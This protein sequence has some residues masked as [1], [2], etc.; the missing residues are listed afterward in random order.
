MLAAA[1]TLLLP[2][3]CARDIFGELRR[4]CR[5][6]RRLRQGSACDVP[7]LHDDKLGPSRACLAATPLRCSS[8]S[9]PI[10]DCVAA[11]GQCCGTPRSTYPR[12][13]VHTTQPRSTPHAAMQLL[14]HA[15]L[16]NLSTSGQDCAGLRCAAGR[17]EAVKAVRAGCDAASDLPPSQS[18]NTSA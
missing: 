12:R 13:P 9:A 15:K 16:M 3:R 1:S 6:Q 2:L 14:L 18:I 17:A 7:G 5:S 8:P 11:P 10:A 4:L